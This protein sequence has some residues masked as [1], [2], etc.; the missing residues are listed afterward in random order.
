VELAAQHRLPALYAQRGYVELG[1]LMSYAYR[2]AE[3]FRVA[4]TYVDK[5]LKGAK[6]GELALTIWDRHYVTVNA[7][8]ASALGLMIPAAVLSQADIIK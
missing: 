8:T 5:I 2:N 1:G 4:A 3:M 7:R 6:P